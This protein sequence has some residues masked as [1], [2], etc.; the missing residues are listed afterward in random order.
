MFQ[1]LL[2]KMLTV[3]DEV[4]YLR[5][6]VCCSKNF[7]QTLDQVGKC[8]QTECKIDKIHKHAGAHLSFLMT[9][10]AKITANIH[11]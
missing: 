1:I 3:A 5:L 11:R 6:S 4:Q 10:A 2:Y 9:S 7:S 8:D